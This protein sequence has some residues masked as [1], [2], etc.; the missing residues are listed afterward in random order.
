MGQMNIIMS[1]LRFALDN[2]TIENVQSMQKF[3]IQMFFSY[4][5]FSDD[6]QLFPTRQTDNHNLPQL[7]LNMDLRMPMTSLYKQWSSLI[8]T[9]AHV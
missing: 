4:R 7:Y 3:S 2:S 9:N 6:T 1:T 5:C 8:L